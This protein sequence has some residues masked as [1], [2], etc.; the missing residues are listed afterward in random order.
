MVK[1]TVRKI[2]YAG[3]FIALNIILTRIFSY[4]VRI[5]SVVGV[6]LSLSQVP[7]VLSG[8]ILGPLYGGF[9]G[10]LSDLVGFPIN[11]QGAYFPGFTISAALMGIV[12]GLV[13]KLIRDRWNL[14]SL[15]ITI[16]I[17]T[18]LTSTILNSLWVYILSG[19][20]AIVLLPPR[21]VA[22]I[23]MIPI[24]IFMVNIFLK[25]YKRIEGQL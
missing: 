3:I 11:S 18:V 22:N 17:T 9:C 5:G 10:A 8:I 23:I 2:V 4:S 21:I 15:S 14:I 24:Y 6:R 13:G 1:N 7:L 16:I 20:A 19:S 12:P 25:H